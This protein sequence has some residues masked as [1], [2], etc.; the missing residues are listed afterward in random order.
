MPS[1]PWLAAAAALGVALLLHQHQLLLQPSAAPA[2]RLVPRSPWPQAPAAVARLARERAPRVLTGSPAARWPAASW[3]SA[4]LAAL[5]ALG[6][7]YV[8]E[9][10]AFTH[11]DADA[12]LARRRPL[13][14]RPPPHRAEQTTAAELLER[15]ASGAGGGTRRYFSGPLPSAHAGQLGDTAAFAVGGAKVYAPQLWIG[16]NTSARLHYDS[17]HNFLL[18]LVGRKRVRLLPPS[19]AYKLRMHPHP[20]PSYR[21][22]RLSNQQTTFEPTPRIALPHPSAAASGAIMIAVALQ[23]RAVRKPVAMSSSENSAPR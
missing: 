21:Q 14:G 16:C 1:S 2:P 3:G 19:E 11:W 10:P 15:C 7:A 4:Q 23:C 17:Q 18:Q 6:A 22:V 13:L 20:H 8:S 5:D 12:P 9:A